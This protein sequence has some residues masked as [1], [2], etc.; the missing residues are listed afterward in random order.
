MS[1]PL[2]IG[3]DLSTY[4]RAARMVLAEKG[5]DYDLQPARPHA[6]E[7]LAIHSFGKIP[8][9]RHGEVE[10]FE[11]LAIAAYADVTFDG[12]AVIPDAARVETLQWCSAYMDNVAANLIAVIL[13]RLVFE[14]PNETRIAELT[15]LVRA[16][17]EIFDA[18]LADRDWLAGEDVTL[19][20]LFL[21]PPMFYVPLL[22]EKAA[23]TDGLENLSRWY[24]RMGARASFAATAPNLAA[25]A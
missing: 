2:I 8:A 9:F 13:E 7:V 15:P 20:D 16:K 5:V 19:A 21:A 10:I 11:T 24:A 18:H 1:K 4:V 23:L 6:P 17:L 14:Q 22:P 3:F 25:A 12:P